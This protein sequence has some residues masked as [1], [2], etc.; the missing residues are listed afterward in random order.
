MNFLLE[1]YNWALLLAALASGAF[2]ALPL[3]RKAQGG[4]LSTNQA[5]MLINREKAV[6]ID[7][8][9]P[10][11]YAR[12]HAAGAKNVP[13]GQLEAA[14]NG[15]PKKKNLPVIVLCATGTRSV[16]AV[17]VLKK[18]GYEQSHALSGGTQA[19]RQAGLPID[20]ATAQPQ[21]A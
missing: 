4:S 21:T 9:E 17:A 14:N 11:D 13:L 7:I 8:S 2:L 1:N 10:A 16:R 3:L 5:V 15:L 18:L 20:R 6:M 12:G 19:W